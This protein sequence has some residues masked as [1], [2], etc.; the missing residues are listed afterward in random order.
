MIKKLLLVI[1]IISIT[2]MQTA[3]GVDLLKRQKIK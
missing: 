3:M 1:T 2:L